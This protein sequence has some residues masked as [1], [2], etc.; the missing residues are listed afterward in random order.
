[1]SLKSTLIRNCKQIAVYWGNPQNDGSGGFTY[2]SPV[3]IKCRWE[4]KQQLMGLLGQ[5]GEGER[6]LSRAV[7]FV[8]QDVDINGL[9]YLG[10]LTDFDS[11][12]LDNPHEVEGKNIFLIKRIESSS[13]LGSTTNFVRKA[14]LT[15]WLT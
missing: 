11:S 7:V 6:L 4:D 9:L 2:D 10:E 13:S 3:E 15:P 8:L 14:F 5:D 1:M 12:D